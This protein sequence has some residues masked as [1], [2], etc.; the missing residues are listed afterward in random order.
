MTDESS[1]QPSRLIPVSGIRGEV[2]QERRGCSA[3]LAVFE[4]VTKFGRAVL[5]PLGAPGGAV[6]TFVE[7]P[8]E[9]GD[10]RVRPDGVIRVVWGKK[11]WTALVEVKT[12]D[13]K[14]RADQ[15]GDYLDLARQEGFDLVLTISNEIAVVSREHPTLAIDK[16]KIKK[17]IGLA[18]ISWS[19][20]HTEAVVERAN[21]QIADS[22]Q[23]WIL[24]ELVRYLEHENSGA[25]DFQDMGENW[26]RVREGA[27]RDSLRPKDQGLI[28]VATRFDQLIAF[29]GLR[30]SRRLG[31]EVRPALTKAEISDIPGRTQAAAATLVKDGALQGRLRVPHA[32]ADIRVITD[33]KAGRVRCSAAIGAPQDRG[34]K[35]RV[36]W[37]LRQLA[38]APDDL[39]IEATTAYQ[40]VPGPS[41]S[42]ADLRD[43][44]ELV[45]LDKSKDIKSF[46]L[47]LSA[48]A[49]TKRGAGRGSF[50]DSVLDLVE[51]FYTEVVQAIKSWTEAAPPPVD[52]DPHGKGSG[53]EHIIGELPSQSTPRPRTEAQEDGSQTKGPEMSRGMESMPV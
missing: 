15:V 4:S 45:I 5:C 21:N 29:A 25:V 11:S 27:A 16:K 2:E 34:Q 6:S 17:G 23:A 36:R 30:L 53:T 9:L 20:I 40:K 42:V 37:L 13:G 38:S 35:A 28:E 49:G 51:L 52:L 1:W 18:H 19:E 12:S 32:A 31:V 44:P 3:L 24:G 8:F 33:L 43:K 39:Q 26:V 22:D 47:T 10:R 46:T 14:L 50:T 41:V 48:R 7:V